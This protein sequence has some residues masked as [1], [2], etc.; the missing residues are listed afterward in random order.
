MFHVLRITCCYLLIIWV[1][2]PFF[3]LFKVPCRL[4]QRMAALQVLAGLPLVQRRYGPLLRTLPHA[5]ALRVSGRPGALLPA[6][7]P[8]TCH[9]CFL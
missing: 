7:A 9:E 3:I 2:W 6:R 4:L 5:W 8:S 1:I